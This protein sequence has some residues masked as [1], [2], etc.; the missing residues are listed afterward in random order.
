MSTAISN[1]SGLSVKPGARTVTKAGMVN[2]AATVMTVSVTSINVS[3]RSPNS[4]ARAWPARA[5]SPENTGMKAALNAPSAKR[6]R[7]RFG[8]RSA[9]KKA[10]ATGPAP[11]T[12]AISRSRTKPRIRLAM[13]YPPTVATERSSMALLHFGSDQGVAFADSLDQFRLDFGFLARMLY[14]QPEN[15]LHIEHIHRPFAVSGDVGGRNLQAELG[16]R[17]SDFVQ[18]P[19]PVAAVDLDHGEIAAGLVVDDN[20]RFHR[21]DGGPA[22]PRRRLLQRLPQVHGARHHLIEPLADAA[23]L[24][25]DP[26]L[27]ALYPKAVHDIAVRQRERP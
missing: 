7:N 20:P 22:L 3:T 16:H 23:V 6:R 12:A 15:V 4:L 11:S 5:S 13:V 17:V 19:R 1:V 10:S 21:K 8:R 18:E 24:G 27:R 25:E 2:S 26:A 9:T 14:L